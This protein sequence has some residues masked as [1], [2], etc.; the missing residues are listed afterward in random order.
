MLLL[1]FLVIQIHYNF[2]TLKILTISAMIPVWLDFDE[3]K[4]EGGACEVAF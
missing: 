4:V 2:R 1:L 3:E